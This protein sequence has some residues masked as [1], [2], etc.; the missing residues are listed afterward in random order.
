MWPFHDNVKDKSGINVCSYILY[1]H[2]SV[3][4]P[5][6]PVNNVTKNKMEKVKELTD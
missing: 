1:V 4:K 2:V 6:L 5:A 3:E